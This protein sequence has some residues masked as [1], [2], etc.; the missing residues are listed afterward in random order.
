MLLQHVRG[1]CARHVSWLR[2]LSWRACAA[3]VH[4]HGVLTSISCSV[5]SLDRGAALSTGAVSRLRNA[6]REMRLGNR[7]MA[8]AKSSALTVHSLV[9]RSDQVVSSDVIALL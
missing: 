4:T 3:A 9:P 6:V 8:E 7:A 5:V 1:T 2:G